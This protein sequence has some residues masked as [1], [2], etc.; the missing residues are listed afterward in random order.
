VSTFASRLSRACGLDRHPQL[1]K[2]AKN[3]V[4][5]LRDPLRRG[6]PLVVGGR[7]LRVP[8]RFARP[9]W[10]DYEPASTAMVAQWL[11]GRPDAHLLDVGSSVGLY[12]LLT[13]GE[14]PQA[15]A[16]ACDS[17]LA[18]LKATQWLCQHVGA[19]RLRPISGFISDRHEVPGLAAEAVASTRRALASPAISREP[20]DAE[21]ICL[22]GTVRSEIAIRSVDGLFPEA[23]ARHPWLLKCDVEGAE[24][25]VLRGAEGFLRRVRPQLLIS[26]HP[27]TLRGFGYEPDDVLAWLRDRG[28]GRRILAVDHE[29]HWWCEPVTGPA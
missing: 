14:S 12:C 4:Y 9:P 2:T 26:V 11:R 13:L 3:L 22:D 6:Q 28:Y 23:D 27:A 17:S 20:S 19:D 8:P 10:T 29:E 5:A 24:M 21:Y 18:S 15:V 1:K 7:T 16:Y 25:L